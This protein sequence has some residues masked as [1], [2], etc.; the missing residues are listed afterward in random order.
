[1]KKY[2][3]ALMLSLSSL[4]H[5]GNVDFTLIDLSY[6]DILMNKT[7]SYYATISAELKRPYDDVS[8]MVDSKEVAG[9][10]GQDSKWQANVIIPKDIG[11]DVF[12]ICIKATYNDIKKTETACRYYKVE[13]WKRFSLYEASRGYPLEGTAYVREL[14]KVRN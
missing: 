7:M 1:M 11:H 12:S 14:P 5:A 10:K 8:I 4:A 3:T 2:I 6:G 9:G 13:F